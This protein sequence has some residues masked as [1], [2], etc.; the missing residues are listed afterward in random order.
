MINFS[1]TTN[2]QISKNIYFKNSL[3]LIQFAGNINNSIQEETT[4]GLRINANSNIG[5]SIAGA[6]R[7]VLSSSL[8]YPNSDLGID[9][10]SNLRRFRNLNTGGSIYNGTTELINLTSTSLVSFKTPIAIDANN[11]IDLDGG[12]STEYIQGTGST[13][14]IRANGSLIWQFSTS[15]N[16][17][18]ADIRIT[19]GRDIFSVV[20][21]SG[22]LGKT[23]SRWKTVNLAEGIYN[24]DT[25]LIHTLKD[26]IDIY[27]PVGNVENRC[28]LYDTTANTL[29]ISVADTYTTITGLSIDEYQGGTVTDSSY[30]PDQAGLYEI[31]F[32]AY[33][34][35]SQNAS[36]VHIS[37]FVND[38]ENKKCEGARLIKTAND[39]GSYSGGAHIRLQGTEELKFRG[40]SANTGTI[41]NDV[42]N[43]RIKRIDD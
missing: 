29:T 27:K 24:D 1:D 35:H 36:D 4:G 43:F 7:L 32:N 31:E 21:S 33:G 18:Y 23:G 8:L 38:V 14:Q 34:T 12:N 9:L 30:T 41:T 40:K 16:T 42:L 17:S 28:E 39:Y 19:G 22:N 2:I 37:L 5:Y 11:I 10:G 15:S 6:T 3:G 25:L 20:D 13:I 26:S